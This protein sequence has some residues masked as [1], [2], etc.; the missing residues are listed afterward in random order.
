LQSGID[1]GIFLPTKDRYMHTITVSPKF[2]I[3]IPKEVR[4]QL[5]IKPGTKVHVIPYQNRIEF[6]PIRQMKAMRGF[7]KRKFDTTIP[8]EQDRI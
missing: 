6:I 8:R 2:Q 3:A 4:E 7:I 1:Y 5:D